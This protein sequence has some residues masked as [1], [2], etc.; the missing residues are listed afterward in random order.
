MNK[1][2]FSREIGRAFSRPFTRNGLPRLLFTVIGMLIPFIGYVAQ[3]AAYSLAAGRRDGWRDWLKLGWR[4][5]LAELLL[6]A[7]AFL[8]FALILLAG[9]YVQSMAA[10]FHLLLLF[11]LSLAAVRW[12]VLAPAAACC[13]T[14][15]APLRVAADAKE[16][17]RVV[18][19]CIGPY[20]LSCLISFGMLFVIGFATNGLLLVPRILIGGALGGLHTLFTAGMFLAACRRALGLPPA[21][22]VPAGAISGGFASGARRFAAFFL[23]LTMLAAVPIQAFAVKPWDED[24]QPLPPQYDEVPGNGAIPTDNTVFIDAHSYVAAY[25]E[26]DRMG[27]LGYGKLLKR[28]S[29]TKQYYV[30]ENVAEYEYH[31]KERE[32]NIDNL[33][34]IADV[35]TDF[36]PVIGHAKNGIQFAY[37]SVRAVTETDP[38]KKLDYNIKAIYKGTAFAIGGAARLLK[39]SAAATGKILPQMLNKGE[40]MDKI[41]DKLIWL[42]RAEKGAEMLEKID[43]VRDYYDT[44][45]NGVAIA[46][47]ITGGEQ[48]SKWTGPD[49]IVRIAVIGYDKVRELNRDVPTRIDLAKETTSELFTDLDERAEDLGDELF[50]LPLLEVKPLPTNPWPDVEWVQLPNGEYQPVSPEFPYYTDA[51]P[52]PAATA[53]PEPSAPPKPAATSNPTATPEPT[54][55]PKPETTPKSTPKPT[56]TPTQEPTPE[57]TPVPT[58]GPGE[59]GATMDAWLEFLDGNWQSTSFSFEPSG[60]STKTYYA[61]PNCNLRSVVE[62]WIGGGISCAVEPD[63]K[64]L[65]FSA[66]VEITHQDK[67]SEF[68]KETGYIFYGNDD[69]VVLHMSRYRGTTTETF[70]RI[71]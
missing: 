48:Y 19:G 58:P 25:N 20:L 45:N 17:K 9:A 7:P 71:G 60:K 41:V 4:I 26:F 27:M 35:G 57:P 70:E 63:G 56:A 32:Q 55:T 67:P 46:D 10:I 59:P 31:L 62:G 42:N 21:Q 13:L 68:V 61:S 11:A 38:Q 34:T 8:V 47:I 51:T 33:I 1:P 36:I 53:T 6:A 12:V 2:G 49:G 52:A 29:V 23:V 22:D 39:G 5:L 69:Y 65:S 43:K 28:D 14:L 16:L 44:F 54:A 40:S 50:K 15:G 3:G 37:Y 18:S 66:T 30:V 24:I 64:T